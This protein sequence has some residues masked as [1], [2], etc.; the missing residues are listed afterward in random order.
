M[1]VLLVRVTSAHD[2]SRVCFLSHVCADI[3]TNERVTLLCAFINENNKFQNVTGILGQLSNPMDTS[4]V[5]MNLTFQSINERV[6]HYSEASLS[7]NFH[8][9]NVLSQP[10]QME[11]RVLYFEE[12]DDD[13]LYSNLFFN[14][15][16][17]LVNPLQGSV[18]VESTFQVLFAVG[19]IGVVVMVLAGERVMELISPSK[20]AAG[21]AASEQGFG[22]NLRVPEGAQAKRSRAGKGSAPNSVTRQRK[23]GGGK[24]KKTN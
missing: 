14:E 10:V 15:T 12:G 16:V 17:Q 5:L 2:F 22:Q 18:T 11:M 1:T 3:P 21:A 13:R 23:R 4:Q 19:V 8:M 20:S 9:G 7:Y 24:K 6:E